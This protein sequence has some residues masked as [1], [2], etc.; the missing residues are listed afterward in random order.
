MKLNDQQK[1]LLQKFDVETPIAYAAGCADGSYDKHEFQPSKALDDMPEALFQDALEEL[2][3]WYDKYSVRYQLPYGPSSY[4]LKHD[5]T[6]ILAHKPDT[7]WKGDTYL[8]N[9]QMKALMILAGFRPNNRHRISPLY[10]IG[11]RGLR[12][13]SSR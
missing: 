12:E 8:T 2:E 5:L 6:R 13:I 1:A 10:K 3:F 9:V 4:A 11:K 7:V